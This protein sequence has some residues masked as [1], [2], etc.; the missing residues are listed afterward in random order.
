MSSKLQK[1]EY[2]CSFCGKVFNRSSTL[3]QHK[4]T[5]AQEKRFMCPIEN[6][7]RQFNLKC[8]M[9]RHDL[10]STTIELLSTTIVI[11]LLN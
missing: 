9:I 8:T 5:H 7:E 1:V 4:F 11:V 3:Y 6:C 2:P 10:L